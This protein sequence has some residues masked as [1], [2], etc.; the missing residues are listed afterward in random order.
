MQSTEDRG[1]ALNHVRQGIVDTFLSLDYNGRIRDSD[2][3]INLYVK[4]LLSLGCFYLE[5]SDGIREGWEP[6]S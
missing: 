1:K 6:G 5:Y 4:R 3:R 2:N